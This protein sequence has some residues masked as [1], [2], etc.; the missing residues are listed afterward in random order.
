MSTHLKR[1]LTL[2]DGTALV[3]GSIIGTGIFLKTATMS[4]YLPNPL[5][6][7]LA[8]VVGGLLSFM[9][10]LT[11]A[12]LGSLFPEAGGEYAYLKRGYGHLVAFLYGWTRFWI[13]APGSIAAYAVGATTFIS[14]VFN[15]QN[16]LYQ[17]LIAIS[18]I[19]LFTILNCA[20]VSFAGKIQSIMTLVK[21]GIMLFLALGIYL[22]SPNVSLDHFTY[23]SDTTFSI[24]SFGMALLA[25][26]WAY[27]GWNNLS[28]VGGEIDKAE[29]NI[30]LS[31][32]IGMFIVLIIYGGI[33]FAYFYALPMEE[34]LSAN[35]KMNPHAL[36]VATKAAMTF[37]GEK[38]LI[39]LSMAF[40]FSSLGA[41][42][43]SILSGARVPFAMAEDKLFFEK[44][45]R[46]SK[47]NGAPVTSLIVQALIAMIL[48][49]SGSFDQL[50]DYVV[51]A[52]WV[53]YGLTATLSFKF[54][55]EG[56]IK[57]EGYWK[58]AYPVLPMTFVGI[59]IW[60]VI[61][62]IQNSFHSTLIGAVFVILGIPA[63]LIFFKP[64][65]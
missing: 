45:G 11:Y 16:H 49:L 64:K 40:V 38:S 56:L 5:W 26:L 51:F 57:K 12:K 42:N 59:T 65:A 44:L 18:L 52:A 1:E 62:T 17:K 34:I 23:S 6:V 47:K 37:L 3:V 22:Y 19:A 25:S 10:A 15:F 39:F 27:D 28:M 9:G 31:L 21:I 8:W 41:M 33:N 30:S 63:Y 60:L 58:W 13:G 55:R 4:N 48:A 43:G 24:S 61:N 46:L 54:T 20:R 14:S 50:T 32:I 2:R 35:S 36:P 53:F 29:K 7:L